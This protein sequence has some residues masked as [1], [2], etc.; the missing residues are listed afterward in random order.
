MMH[1]PA[2]SASA[3]KLALRLHAVRYEAVDI[4][5][6]EWRAADGRPLPPFAAGA[7]IELQL[8]QLARSYS[9]I[10]PGDA[11]HRRYVIAVKRDASSRGG[12]RFVHDALRVGTILPASVPR[13]HFALRED[14]AHSVL[15]AGGIGITPIWS[16]VQRLTQL[17]GSWEL[18]Y[19]ARSEAH[20]AFAAP[21][22]VLAENGNGIVHYHFDDRDGPFDLAHAVSHAAA[23]AHLYCC[24][25]A[26][27]LTAFEAACD[28]S[29]ALTSRDPGTIH[30]ERFAAPAA[31]P[32]TH[33]AGAFTVILA[34]ADR[35]VQ[36]APGMTILDA[37]LAAGLTPAF[38][39]REGV[40][41]SCETAVL[42]GIPDHRDSVL[43]A[44]ERLA[45]RSMMIC[46]SGC[47][48]EALVLDM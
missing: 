22:R 45:N 23:D 4:V 14:A 35:T 1:A 16:M 8:G 43:S 29:V 48:G 28:D 36:V 41:G 32:A 2:A 37:L 13:N 11:D 44:T 5:S 46:C 19:C 30:L 40:C 6:L 7:H 9:L 24:G 18:H 25:P 20:A 34:R 17:G 21:I 26:P 31:A 3:D 38:S 42:D 39:C 27:M 10:N 15:F 33:Q 12:S 47:K